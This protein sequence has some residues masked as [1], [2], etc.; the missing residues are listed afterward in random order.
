MGNPLKLYPTHYKKFSEWVILTEVKQN[1]LKT[2]LMN[3]DFKGSG[4]K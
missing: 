4:G 1:S 2:A 3:F